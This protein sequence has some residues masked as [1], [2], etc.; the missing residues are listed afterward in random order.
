MG[1]FLCDDVIMQNKDLVV[2]K[3]TVSII[4]RPLEWSSL[5]IQCSNKI[6]QSMMYSSFEGI[7][8]DHRSPQMIP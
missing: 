6:R 5:G 7:S 1:M 8:C 4:L 2:M 3:P